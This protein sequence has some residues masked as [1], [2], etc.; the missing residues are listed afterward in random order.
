[1]SAR[2]A[3]VTGAGSGIGRATALV[4]H[5]NDY[6][7]VVAGRRA[8][9]LEETANLAAPAEHKMLTV[10]TDVTDP[11]SVRRLFAEAVA[12]FGR[13]DVLF[14]NAGTNVRNTPLEDLTFEQWTTVVNTNLTGSFLCA[15]QA[16]RVMKSQNPRG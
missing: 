14:N 10:Q 8:S 4:F 6:R 12:A 3:V 15:Q 7:V 13:V 11:E 1:M 16:I 5:S 9:Q 2:V